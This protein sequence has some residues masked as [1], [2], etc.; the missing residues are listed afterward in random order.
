MTQNYLLNEIW[1]FRRSDRQRVAISRYGKFV[2]FSL[3]ALAVNLGV[4]KG[5]ID[6]FAFPLLVIPQA[7]GIGAATL[8]NF[9]T[10]R[11]VTF[12]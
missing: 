7:V 3:L 8:L 9:V 2:F 1:T 12:R 6:H 5:L 11:F 10:S 4:L